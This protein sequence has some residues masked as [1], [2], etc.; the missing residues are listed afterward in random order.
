M[1]VE[2]YRTDFV[3]PVLPEIILKSF[4]TRVGMAKTVSSSSSEGIT[5]ATANR[6]YTYLSSASEPLYSHLCWR[7]LRHWNLNL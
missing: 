7:T 2:V 1:S 6:D 4:E 3:I 5:L